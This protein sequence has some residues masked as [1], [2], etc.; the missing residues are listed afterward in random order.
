MTFGVLSLLLVY[1]VGT[2][3]GFLFGT[4]WSRNVL[5]RA[6]RVYRMAQAV[7]IVGEMVLAE[8]KVALEKEKRGNP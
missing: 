6:R 3:V 4:W 1:A 8:V 5:E 7:I 2:V